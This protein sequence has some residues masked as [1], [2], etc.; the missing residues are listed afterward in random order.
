MAGGRAAG[1]PER[2]GGAEAVFRVPRGRGTS[3]LENYKIRLLGQ[4]RERWAAARP[5]GAPLVRVLPRYFKLCV[6]VRKSA[7]IR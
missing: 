1:V 2:E 7:V 3:L 4:D 6:A 5:H